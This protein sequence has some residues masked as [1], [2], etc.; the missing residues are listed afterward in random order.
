MKSEAM[1]IQAKTEM[2][3]LLS[4]GLRGSERNLTRAAFWAMRLN[5]LSDNRNTYAELT[6]IEARKAIGTS[7]RS[8]E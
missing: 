8:M 4:R 5:H 6:L 3:R 1:R 7:Q 2:D